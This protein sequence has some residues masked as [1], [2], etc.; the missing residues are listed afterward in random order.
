VSLER[1]SLQFRLHALPYLW[2][3]FWFNLSRREAVAGRTVPVLALRAGSILRRGCR[4]DGLAV[5]ALVVTHLC[6]RRVPGIAV[7]EFILLGSV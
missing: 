7:W 4:I 2:V 3:G 6:A 1:Q 5:M